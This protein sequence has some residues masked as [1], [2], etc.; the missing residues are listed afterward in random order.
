MWTWR[1]L[2]L[3]MKRAVD[4]GEVPA[5][6]AKDSDSWCMKASG[7]RGKASEVKEAKGLGC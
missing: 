7:C 4:V 5:V 6:E 1:V 2:T 3:D